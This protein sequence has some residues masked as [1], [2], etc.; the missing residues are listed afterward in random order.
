VG[1]ATQTREIVVEEGW[2]ERTP[3]RVR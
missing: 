1:E 2:I 3:G